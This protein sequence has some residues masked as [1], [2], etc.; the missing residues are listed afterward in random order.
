MASFS[1]G[2]LM[3]GIN[4]TELISKIMELKRE[5]IYRLQDKQKSYNDKVSVYNTLSS[6]LSTLKSAADKLRTS[7]NFYAKA[8]SVTD[9]D[10]LTASSSSSATAGTYSV[11]ITQLAYAHS[12]T[13]STG[14]T[15]KSTTTVLASGSTFRFTINGET[16]TITA[17]SNL[18]LEGLASQINAQTYTGSV[19]VDATVVNTGTTASPSYKLVL[20][21]NTTGVDYGITINQDDSTLNLDT[22]PSTIQAA[23][24][25]TFSVNG[26]SVARSSNT[27][28]DVITG[29]TLNLKKA[30]SSASVSVAND[31]NT[32]KLNIEAFVNSY[33]D[34]VSYVSSNSTYNAATKKGSPLNGEATSRS[35]VNRLSDVITSAVSGL[36]SDMNA[37]SHLGISTDYTTGTLKID[38]ATL[39]SKLDTDLSDVA[40]LFTTATTGVANQMYTYIDD[41]T[42]TLDGSVTVRVDGLEDLVSDISDDIERLEGSLEKEE[43]TLTRQFSSLETLLAGLSAQSSFLSGWMTRLS[44]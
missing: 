26:L 27:V 10:V 33:N 1:V 12:I 5:P 34:V 16:K 44:K 4:Y 23:Q 14:L 19:E 2:G 36:P 24:N 31:V 21:S 22:A 42:D 8:A 18:T 3:S 38:S 25:A 35:I 32:I 15:D 6:K 40:S 29:V 43:E 20:A 9:S 41:A 13:H 7:S 11:S 30:A 39:G 17:S 37:L 28:S